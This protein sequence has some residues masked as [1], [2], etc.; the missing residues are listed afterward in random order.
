LPQE[1]PRL[2]DVVNFRDLSVPG[3]YE[4]I[5]TQEAGSL[6]SG[7]SLNMAAGESDLTKLTKTELDRLFGEQRYAVSR[8]LESLVRTVTSG[9]LGQ[10]V[11]GLVVAVLV[12]V[13]V[14]EQIV[15]AWF[16]RTDERPGSPT[17]LAAPHH[18]S[19]ASPKTVSQ[20]T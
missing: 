13:F 19:I 4:L 16:Y 12:G 18:K 8:E 11:Y 3:H 10:E 1:I 14:L 17:V 6:A 15:G 2:A 9:R 20:R 5:S 7:F